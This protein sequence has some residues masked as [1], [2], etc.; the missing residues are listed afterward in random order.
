[1]SLREG[2]G[3]LVS[4]RSHSQ[5][6]GRVAAEGRGKRGP[7]RTCPVLS[8][9]LFAAAADAGPVTVR[10]QYD[11]FSARNVFIAGEFNGWNTT[12]TPL[13]KDRAGLWKG[14]LELEPG[15]YGY[16]FVV[17]GDWR[18]DPMN[19][20]RVMV[21]HIENSRLVVNPPPD[22]RMLRDWV[23][24]S[25][26][27]VKARL[28]SQDG[29]YIVL[30]TAASNR[31][32]ITRA[33]L[34]DEDLIFLED[35]LPALRGPAAATVHS[36]GGRT[37]APAAAPPR[38]AGA[39]AA[40]AAAPPRPAIAAPASYQETASLYNKTIAAYQE[41]LRTRRDPA[42]LTEI[43]ATLRVCAEGFDDFRNEAPAGT[44]C[45]A[46]IDQCNRAIFAVHATRLAPE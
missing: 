18:F 7:F 28:V 33:T 24:E 34:S 32:R 20:N 16:K 8:A 40:A 19:T 17:D 4:R 6:A 27:S 26:Q 21:D 39:A 25:G 13:K 46:L 15:S 30:E 38:V 35:A 2:G 14:T 3:F 11:N 22:P 42:R 1:M 37:S 31:V 5:G 45:D 29:A 10:I 43:E 9:L 41:F 36:A 12:A 44:N 23:S